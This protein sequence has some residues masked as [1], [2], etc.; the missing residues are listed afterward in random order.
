MDRIIE[1][2]K[3]LNKNSISNIGA[4]AGLENEKDKDYRIWRISLLGPKDTPY[5]GGVFLLNIEFPDEYPIK[6]PE[7]Y[8]KTPIYHLNV[9]PRA[10]RSP[11]DIPLG[12]VSISTLSWWK[13]EYK[14]REVLINIY[15]LFYKANPESPY[16]LARAEEY[17]NN[18]GLYEEKI[19]FFSRKYA[20]PFLQAKNKIK[21]ERDKDWDFEYK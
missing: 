14:I 3:D 8:F 16:G 11:E 20:H 19:K 15:A 18:R 2:F 13:P 12:H 10:P 21:Y 7:V 9:N 5:K 4:T 1:E 6:P 17:R